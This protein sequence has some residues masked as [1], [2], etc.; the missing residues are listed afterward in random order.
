MHPR[1]SSEIIIAPDGQVTISFLTT[2]LLD[3]A[4]SLDPTD[5]KL[6]RFAENNR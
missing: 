6:A 2:E 5:K 1:I 4:A 3:V